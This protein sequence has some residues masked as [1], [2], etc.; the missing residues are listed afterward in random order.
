LCAPEAGMVLDQRAA[1]WTES[2]TLL[3]TISNRAML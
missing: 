3:E 2:V 1:P